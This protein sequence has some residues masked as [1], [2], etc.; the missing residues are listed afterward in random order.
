MRGGGFGLLGAFVG[1]YRFGLAVISTGGGLIGSIV[2]AT[3]GVMVLLF[4][5]RSVKRA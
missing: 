4:L 2:S 1:D 5:I 3:V